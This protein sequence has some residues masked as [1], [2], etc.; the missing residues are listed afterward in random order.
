M[1]RQAFLDLFEVIFSKRFDFKKYV[2][3]KSDASNALANPS[4][5]RNVLTE[6]EGVMEVVIGSVAGVESVRLPRM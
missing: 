6:R 5:M 4:S 1:N 2:G 3:Y